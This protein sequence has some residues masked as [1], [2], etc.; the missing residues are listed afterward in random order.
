MWDTGGRQGPHPDPVGMPRS[1]LHCPRGGGKRQAGS[2]HS[3]RPY[4][5]L[6]A[7]RAAI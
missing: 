7:S 4:A 2:S 6:T 3:T 5:L 1:A